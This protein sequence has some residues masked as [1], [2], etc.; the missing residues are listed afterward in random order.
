MKKKYH[1]LENEDV[2]PL[3]IGGFNPFEK[4]AARQIGFTFPKVRVEN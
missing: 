4:Y 3:Q 2:E 1:H